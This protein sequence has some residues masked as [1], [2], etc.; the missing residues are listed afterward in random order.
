MTKTTCSWE[1]F[2]LLGKS[3][4]QSRVLFCYIA[5]FC[6]LCPALPQVNLCEKA[7]HGYRAVFSLAL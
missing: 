3:R 4:D 6:W 2:K 7:T 5:S 1:K